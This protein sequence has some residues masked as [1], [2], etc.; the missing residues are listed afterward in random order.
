MLLLVVC[1]YFYCFQLEKF[2][3]RECGRVKCTCDPPPTTPKS[4]RSDPESSCF[5]YNGSLANQNAEDVIEYRNNRL[6]R[7]SNPDV[8]A[9][10]DI[11]NNLSQR[12]SE[13]PFNR[14]GDN[15]KLRKSFAIRSREGIENLFSFST[16][17]KSGDAERLKVK[18]RQGVDN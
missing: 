5:G 4:I 14:F 8:N 18:S 17:K 7:L 6:S 13:Q 12:N 9:Q 16:F 3:C 11:R 15:G 2:L 10:S 1:M